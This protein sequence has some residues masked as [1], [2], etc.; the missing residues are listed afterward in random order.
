MAY[1]G[2]YIHTLDAANRLIV[3]SRF[4]EALGPEAVLYNSYDGGIFVYDQA[5]FDALQ[6][7]NQ[8]LNETEAGRAMLRRF[9]Q[10]VR[11][12]SIDRSGRFV[13]PQE[14]IE[15]AGLKNE[16]V[17][18]GVGKRIEVWDLERYD[19]NVGDPDTLPQSDYPTYRF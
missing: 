14:C 19:A 3:P 12:V 6:E 2:K 10:D 11:T 5:A 15:H 17:V 18:L 13:M 9:Y 1:Y 7:Q 8:E 16:I 4:R